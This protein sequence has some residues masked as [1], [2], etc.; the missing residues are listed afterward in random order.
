MFFLSYVCY[1]FV[2]VCLYVICGH[3]L[4]K[5]LPLGSRLWCLLWV[6]H[7]PIGIL[8]QVWYLIVSIPDLC[9]LNYFLTET[10]LAFCMHYSVQWLS[11]RHLSQK[12][13]SNIYKIRL[14]G[15]NANLFYF[16]IADMYIRYNVWGTKVR[17]TSNR[18]IVPTKVLT[19]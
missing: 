7:F 3:L 8:G 13:T 18:T 11:I 17:P 12:Q 15:L 14:F 1:V 16:L 6:C 10:P 4:G 5:G 9:T 2:R 19:L